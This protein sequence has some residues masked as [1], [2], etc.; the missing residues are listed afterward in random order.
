M[1]I[2]TV[3][4]IGIHDSIQCNI[5]IPVQHHLVYTSQMNNQVNKLHPL[6]P[7]IIGRTACCDCIAL[8]LTKLFWWSTWT[9]IWQRICRAVCMEK[10]FMPHNIVVHHGPTCMVTCTTC[11][12]YYTVHCCI[13][14]W[15]R[16]GVLG[17]YHSRDM[18][19]YTRRF[20][21]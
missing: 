11:T 10:M 1:F 12:G 6:Q 19:N 21:S 5:N 14:L 4:S 2:V 16:V 8:A 9:Y 13:V 18:F 15:M 17:T 7:I 3:D 20:D